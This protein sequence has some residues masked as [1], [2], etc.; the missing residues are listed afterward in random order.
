MNRAAKS[1]EINK[2]LA[3]FLEMLPAVV[4][5]HEGQYALLRHGEI[6]EFFPSAIE[7]QI[8]G[9]RRFDDFIFS[10]QHVKET[11]E[12]LGYFS[13]AINNGET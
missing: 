3:R 12:E 9:N 8:A 6:V 1:A 7:A 5:D 11:A 2:N 4:V 13:C 10:I